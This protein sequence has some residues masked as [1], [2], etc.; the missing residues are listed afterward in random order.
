MEH[1]STIASASV[2]YHR[3]LSTNSNSKAMS[4][5]AVFSVR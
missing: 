2:L 4:A 5:D 3:A 1:A